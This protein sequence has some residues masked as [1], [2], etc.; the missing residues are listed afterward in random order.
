MN[1]YLAAVP[2]G[3]KGSWEVLDLIIRLDIMQ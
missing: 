3:D 2:G 1:H